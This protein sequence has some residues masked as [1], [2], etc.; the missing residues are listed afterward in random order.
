MQERILRQRSDADLRVYVVWMPVMPL[1]ERFG[2]ADVLVD[3]RARHFWDGEQRISDVVGRSLETDGLAWDIYL[4]Y[5][6]DSEW[7]AE[8]PEPVSSGAPVVAR[9]D[10]LETDLARFVD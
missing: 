1:D 7:E 2:V 6:P 4:L 5:G 9:I 3:A 8:L 10:S